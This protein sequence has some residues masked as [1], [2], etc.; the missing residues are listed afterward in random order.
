M[1][2]IG[3]FPADTR[4]DRAI[5]A[6]GVSKTYRQGIWP[7]RRRDRVL[8]DVSLSLHRGEIVGLV[9]ENGRA[10]RR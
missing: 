6:S 8:D 7:F 1:D 3:N 10:S 2:P 9:G 5:T 4:A